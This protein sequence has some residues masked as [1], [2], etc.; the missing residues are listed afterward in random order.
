MINT[1]CFVLVTSWRISMY[2]RFSP[3]KKSPEIRF[4]GLCSTVVR[5]STLGFHF[6]WS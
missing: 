4:R 1:C 6:I 5:K 3:K 2:R